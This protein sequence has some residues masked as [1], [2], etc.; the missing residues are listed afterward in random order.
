V[1]LKTDWLVAAQSTDRRSMNLRDA[2]TRVRRAIEVITPEFGIAPPMARVKLSERVPGIFDV[3]LT[4]DD[5]L[6]PIHDVT[7]QHVL[8]AQIGTITHES[9]SRP[10]IGSFDPSWLGAAHETHEAINYAARCLTLTLEGVRP[11]EATK[12]PGANPVT[13]TK[14]WHPRCLEDRLRRSV[15]FGLRPSRPSSSVGQSPTDS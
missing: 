10:A 5:Y 14:R 15:A 8:G 13:R 1:V 7:I 3:T 11:T 12:S 9:D 4:D 2:T 6:A